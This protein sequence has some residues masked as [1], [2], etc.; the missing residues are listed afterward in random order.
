MPGV[1]LHEITLPLLPDGDYAAALV[2]VLK[3]SIDSTAQLPFTALVAWGIED[4]A[5]F[6][7]LLASAGIVIPAALSVVLLGRTDLVNEHVDF[8]HTVGCSVAD[9]VEAL[10]QAIL[11]RWTDPSAPYGVRLTP[12]T[13]RTGTSVAPPLK[14]VPGRRVQR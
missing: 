12:V 11:A 10:H 8:F 4:G 7:S 13:A 3:A 9:Q 1:E 6:H 2:D 5:Q 14:A